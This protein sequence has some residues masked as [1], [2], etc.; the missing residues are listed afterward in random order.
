MNNILIP[1]NFSASSENLLNYAKSLGAKAKAQL[2]FVYLGG[3]KFLKNPQEN[4]LTQEMDFPKFCANIKTHDLQGKVFH[5]YT[6]LEDLG[7][8]VTFV[9]SKSTG[10]SNI[11]R[12]CNEGSYDLLLLD[13]QHFPGIRSYFQTALTAKIIDEVN[14]PV[15]VVP[16]KSSYHEIKHIT[17]AVD[18]QAYDAEVIDQIRNIASLFDA[19]LTLVHVNAKEE[20]DKPEAYLPSLEK[21]IS[22]T[23]DYPK[24]YY[25]FFDHND[26]FT[27]IKHFVKQ[28]NPSL[29]AM[30]NRKRF[31]WKRLLVE[32]SLTRKMAQDLPVPLLAFRKMP[33]VETA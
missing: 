18:L 4:T 28:N 13:L 10:V 29:L 32:K 11:V 20:E 26:P 8:R 9:F 5:L 25:K 31:S 21:T 30:I 24:V 6:Q 7:I 33:V 22:A 14:S 27:G 17:Y 15:F 19:K 1:I 16:A 23:I 3:A 12:T 2:T